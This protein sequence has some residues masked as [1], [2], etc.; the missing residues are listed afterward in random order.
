MLAE[1]RPRSID[2][3]WDDG[4]TMTSAAR[5]TAT[6]LSLRPLIWLFHLALP[7]AGLALLLTN[8][9]LD[10]MWQ[11]NLAHFWLVLGTAIISL[12][13]AALVLRSA[14]THQDARLYL[15]ALGFVSAAGALA[16][17]ALATPTVVVAA[18]N[19]AFNLATPVGL[20]VGAAFSAWA[21]L[22]LSPSAAKRIIQRR[23]WL[24]GAVAVGLVAWAALSVVPGSPLL[25]P[26]P[27]DQLRL[28]L[29]TLAVAGVAMYA[30]AAIRSYVRYRVR[31]SVV[32]L[33]LIT[34][35]VLL[36][37][38][39]VATAEAP[40][41]HVSW[42]LWHVLMAI[43]FA[44][45]GYAAHVEY[46]RE[47]STTSLFTAV[48]M[49]ETIRRLQD[50]YAT[51][52][53]DLVA[54]IEAGGGESAS[55]AAADAS[56][57]AVAARLQTDVGLSDGQ[58]AVLREA[59]S[60]LAEERLQGRRL[61]AVAE[62]GRRAQV[63][64]GDAALALAAVTGLRDAFPGDRL[65]VVAAPV[66]E[67]DPAAAEAVD[68]PGPAVAGLVEEALATGA[69]RRATQGRGEALAIP[70]AG[71]PKATRALVA[72]RTGGPFDDRAVAVLE[73][74]ATQLAAGL[75]NARLYRQVDRL[76]RAYLSPDVARSLLEDPE[77][78][79]L[80]GA[81]ADVSVLFADLRDYTGFSGATEPGAVVELLNRYFGAIVPDILAEG[82]TVAQF[83]GDA[84]MAIW[85]APHPHVDH[86][87]RA[88]R[89]ALRIRDRVDQTAAG[90]PE[91]PRFRFGIATGRAIV[92]NIGAAEVRSYTAIGATTNLAARLQTYGEPG[93]I[94]VSAETARQGGPSLR[95]APLGPI[96]LKGFSG[97][98]EAFDLLGVE[99]QA[100]SPA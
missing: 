85:G 37:E 90:H 73:T 67:V 96:E 86:A 88:C 72:E 35:M 94:I 13:I 100:V 51:A 57:A 25:G 6:R 7:L 92:G 19:A 91:W 41:W 53:G 45:I 40:N 71:T 54:A 89:A 4:P 63:R 83:A 21:V 5:R 27:P 47:G 98:V 22:E 3:V 9:H 18:P 29:R 99:P 74:A 31:P 44:Y 65:S 1:H 84:I 12:A 59:A 76:F 14:G 16:I 82:G 2:L 60:A 75:E 69:T 56:V 58:A 10:V 30:F 93:R 95:V 64:T 97:S 87:L 80:G 39:L 78:A 11:D 32:T 62:F 68:G 50:R 38:A 28:I 34:T 55:G 46:R 48:S 79:R 33:S 20:V 77:R 24:V 8:P 52:L 49:E 23:Y 43:G 81:E 42:W 66:L 36:A 15:V 61:A 26:A 70:L 17:H